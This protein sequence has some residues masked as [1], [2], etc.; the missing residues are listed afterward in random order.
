MTKTHIFAFI[1]IGFFL[2]ALPNVSAQKKSAPVAEADPEPDD[3]VM[4]DKEAVLDKVSLLKAFRYPDP[5]K[6]NGIQGTVLVH[7]L[8]GKKGNV[9][10][11]LIKEA[12]H[13]LLDTAAVMACMKA[14]FT[15]AV[16]ENKPIKTWMS[17]PI[18]FQLGRPKKDP[19]DEEL[20]K[21]E[22]DGYTRPKYNRKEFKSKIEYPDV[23]RSNGLE[24]AVKV[25]VLVDVSGKVKEIKETSSCPAVLVNEVK[26]VIGKTEF[27]CGTLNGKPN[28]DW[29][30]IVVPFILK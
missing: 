20:A 5:A 17:I 8:I 30:S 27:T 24:C 2:C 28:E 1:L 29:V 26:R 15:P 23:A 13:P 4:M 25:D 12:V 3:F 14:T 6:K 22:G 21:D 19:N 9:E 18:I 16:Y 11:Y 7:V 10:R